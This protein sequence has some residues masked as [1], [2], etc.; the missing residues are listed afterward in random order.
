MQDEN[1]VMS[2]FFFFGSNNLKLFLGYKISVVKAWKQEKETLKPKKKKNRERERRENFFTRYSSLSLL[3]KWLQTRVASA[4]AV[5][6]G[7]QQG[8]ASLSAASPFLPPFPLPLAGQRE[9]PPRRGSSVWRGP[10]T[11]S[12]IHGLGL[13]VSLLAPPIAWVVAVVV[14]GHLIV[15]SVSLPVTA[16]VF[17]LRD[18]VLSLAP[19]LQRPTPA[20]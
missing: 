16:V 5:R 12:V 3:W 18:C 17:F 9:L 8:F 6:V 4:L 20:E 7:S 10:R 11:P 14:V 13:S 2:S 1:Y 19:P 15:V